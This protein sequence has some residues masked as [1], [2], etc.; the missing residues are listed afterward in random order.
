MPDHFTAQ[1]TAKDKNGN[2]VEDA[3]GKKVQVGTRINVGP[4]MVKHVLH[5]LAQW[6]ALGRR[7]YRSNNR[8][9][10]E[11]EMPPRSLSNVIKALKEAGFL[12]RK[13]RSRLSK[14]YL[15]I[16]HW[17][18]IE[19]SRRVRYVPPFDEQRELAELEGLGDEDDLELEDER[20]GEDG[21]GE[22]VSEAQQ[23]GLLAREL[24]GMFEEFNVDGR[25]ALG[26]V[27]KLIKGRVTK[28]KSFKRV[29]LGV[30]ALERQQ[31]IAVVNDSIQR[32]AAYLTKVLDTMITDRIEAERQGD[33]QGGGA[34]EEENPLSDDDQRFRADCAQNFAHH[35]NTGEDGAP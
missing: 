20:S 35:Y 27:T 16:L 30:R 29:Q 9:A 2:W 28:F 19:S 12:T 13:S 34:G 8:V 32:P 25:L 24:H 22:E 10:H 3:S 11:L 26:E 7:F 17:D 18:V 21:D 33:R 31:L 23:Q 14:T 6:D 4:Q 15:W 5:Y 1:I